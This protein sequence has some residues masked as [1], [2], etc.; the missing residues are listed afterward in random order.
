MWI[1]NYFICLCVSVLLA[2][3]I[4][5]NIMT[6][7]FKRKLFDEVD[8][9]KIHK[10]VVPRLG[11]IAF[12]PAFVFSY[13]AVVGCNIRLST[14]GFSEMLGGSLVP[15]SF[16]LCALMLMFMVGIADD[17]V[18]VRYSAKF[19]FQI[20]A[21]VLL[22]LSGSWI[23]N[24]Y[25]F[26][27]LDE[28][29]TVIGWILTVFFVLY[30]MNAINLI[31]GIDGLASGLSAIALIF[32]SYLFFKAGEYSY[33]FLS[34]A[35]LG[36]LIPFFYYNVFGKEERHNKIFMGDTGS[37]TIGTVLAF[38]SIRVLNLTTDQF[39][40]GENLFVL[41]MAPILV[42]MMDVAR[43]FLHR[44]RHKHNPFLPDKCHIHHK[45]LAMGFKQWQALITILALDALF[46]MINLMASA[47]F[48]CTL[49]MLFDVVLYSLLNIL[50]T[51]AIRSR[52]RKTHTKLYD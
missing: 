11:G 36:T 3:W 34:G 26:L 6:I 32:Y 23:H 18:G 1:E 14:C 37:L 47:Y 4:I 31:D 51:L 24:M 13:F 27:G 28:I 39:A 46:I 44:V 35:T 7:A 48:S 2:G 43:V 5:P 30:V 25:G 50:L 40:G 8:E 17:L 33:S 49:I 15:I 22:L 38:L 45:F 20:V 52:E 29:L 16:L 9:R 41:A 10:G 42:P 12:L 19:V 21:A